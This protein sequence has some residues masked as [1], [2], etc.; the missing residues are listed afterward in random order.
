MT[1]I[2]GR[3]CDQ[4]HFISTQSNEHEYLINPISINYLHYPAQVH[5]CMSQNAYLALM[6]TQVRI[7]L[8][9]IQRMDIF[10]K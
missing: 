8:P 10:Y 7:S 1:F 9:L 5:V 6:H 3:E 2:I 4:K